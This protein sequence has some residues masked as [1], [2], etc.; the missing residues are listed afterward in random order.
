MSV[1]KENRPARGGESLDAEEYQREGPSLATSE[2][3]LP[4]CGIRQIDVGQL[5][6][7]GNLK[8]GKLCPLSVSD[9]EEA[10]TRMQRTSEGY[11]RAAETFH[12]LRVGT[13]VA[14]RYGEVAAKWPT[15]VL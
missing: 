5:N 9:S 2:V 13:K 8:T 12:C 7:W 6:R 4:W 14:D 10:V 11:S 1:F 3:K 15:L